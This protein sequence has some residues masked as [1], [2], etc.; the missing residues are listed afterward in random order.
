M[1]EGAIPCSPHIPGS[2]I[3]WEDTSTST[4]HAH[5]LGIESELSQPFPPGGNW[6]W[7]AWPNYSEMDGAALWGLGVVS[8]PKEGTST[9][10]VGR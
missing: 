7:H 9:V 8:E 4:A 5:R 3:S 10:P 1:S 2:Q 6:L